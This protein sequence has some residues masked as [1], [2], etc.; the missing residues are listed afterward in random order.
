MKGFD[1]RAACTALIEAGATIV[2]SFE[3]SFPQGIPKDQKEAYEAA[4]AQLAK[5]RARLEQMSKEKIE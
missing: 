2:S 3:T 5:D 1:I 4:K